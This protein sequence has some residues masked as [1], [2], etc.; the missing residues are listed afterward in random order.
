MNMTSL[1]KAIKQWVRARNI[2]TAKPSKQFL[3]VVEEV[4]ELAE[5]LAKSNLDATQDAVGDVFVTLVSLCE[6][7]NIDITDCVEQAYDEI[8]DR[9]G[10]MI[11]GVFVKEEP[12]NGRWNY[13][14][15]ALNSNDILARRLTDSLI[16]DGVAVSEYIWHE[17]TQGSIWEIWEDDM[18]TYYHGEV[19]R[20]AVYGCS[21]YV[22]F[23]F[24]GNLR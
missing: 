7:L 8:K 14:R 23:R 6:T 5:G 11:N 18:T 10:K 13:K 17:F 15:V 16:K 24:L 21:G 20:L 4:G 3:K 19:I 1:T 2:H 22:E 12:Q 9:E